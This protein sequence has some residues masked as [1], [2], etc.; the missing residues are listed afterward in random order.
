MDYGED[1]KTGVR[2]L[3]L[4]LRLGMRMRITHGK[5][6]INAKPTA[7]LRRMDMKRPFRRI[8]ASRKRRI[9]VITSTAAMNCHRMYYSCKIR[10]GIGKLVG[11]L[12]GG[13]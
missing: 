7:S 13:G 1:Y 4:G 10:D 5:R 2:P 8:T 6:N 3:G 12:G 11:W 9:S